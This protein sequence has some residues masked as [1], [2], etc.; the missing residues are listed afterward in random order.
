MDL[1]PCGKWRLSGGVWF[2]P[3]AQKGGAYCF[4]PFHCSANSRSESQAPTAEHDPLPRYSRSNAIWPPCKWESALVVWMTVAVSLQIYADMGGRSSGLRRLTA[5]S[6]KFCTVVISTACSWVSLDL[7]QRFKSN[8][9]QFVQLFRF[10][11]SFLFMLSVLHKLQT[12]FT[13]WFAWV[14]A[15]EL[16]KIPVHIMS[17]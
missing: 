11:F 17:T 2:L 1:T 3:L 15:H 5:I 6:H 13:A 16:Q 10:L 14:V 4:T 9:L 12:T 8:S 7:E